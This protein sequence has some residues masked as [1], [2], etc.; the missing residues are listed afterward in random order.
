MG[1]LENTIYIFFQNRFFGKN[2]FLSYIGVWGS[3]FAH[4]THPGASEHLSFPCPQQTSIYAVV[5]PPTLRIC[6]YTA[7][8]W[9]PSNGDGRRRHARGLRADGESA[10]PSPMEPWWGYQVRS[11]LGDNV[12]CFLGFGYCRRGSRD[13]TVHRI[14]GYRTKTSRDNTVQHR[15]ATTPYSSLSAPV[16]SVGPVGSAPRPRAPTHLPSKHA[17]NGTCRRRHA[18]NVQ[19]HGGRR[20]RAHLRGSL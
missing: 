10:R 18:T 8:R 11:I 17:T 3:K 2:I 4:R 20:L 19:H 12:T 7:S 15:G 5:R 6:I 16:T 1:P 13:A 14:R 9:R